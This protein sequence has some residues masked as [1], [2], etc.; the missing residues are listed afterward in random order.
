MAKTLRERL[1]IGLTAIGETQVTARTQK[2]VVFTRKEGGYYY[3]G[4]H[5]A[6]RFGT[7]ASKSIPC[8]GKIYESLLLH[9]A[10]EGA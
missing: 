4:T 6:L 3:I 10:K 7:A 9:T 1:I 8:S 5:G 2:Y